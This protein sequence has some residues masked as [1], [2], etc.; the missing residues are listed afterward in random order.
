MVE[1]YQSKRFELGQSFAERFVASLDGVSK[2]LDVDLLLSDERRHLGGLVVGVLVDDTDR[3]HDRSTTQTEVVASLTRVFLAVQ[4]LRQA[5][6]TVLTFHRLRV[7][8]RMH[9]VT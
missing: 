3:A 8:V 4:R 6:S 1:L 9:A 2:T 5:R 7:H